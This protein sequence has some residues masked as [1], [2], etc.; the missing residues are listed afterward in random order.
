MLELSHR[1]WCGYARGAAETQAEARLMGSGGDEMRL[2]VAVSSR[3]DARLFDQDARLD[4]RSR[5]HALSGECNL[6]ARSINAWASFI[7]RYLGVPFEY[8]RHLQKSYYRQSGRRLRAHAGAQNGPR[9]IS[10]LCA[11]YRSFSVLAAAPL[12]RAEIERLPG[13]GS[14]HERLARHAERV[15]EK[16]GVLDLFEDICDIA[17]VSSCRSLTPM[18]SSA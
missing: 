9:G 8:A 7:A 12:L 14:F 17:G 1:S 5:Q 2:G 3:E 11:R 13:A 4:L 16:L 18:R 15:A 10:R 6:F